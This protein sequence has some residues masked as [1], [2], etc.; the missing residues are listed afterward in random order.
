MLTKRRVL[1]VKQETTPGTAESLSASEG[2]LVVFDPDM[3][4][5]IDMQSRDGAGHLGQRAAVPGA[6]SAQCTFS[7][8]LGGSGSVGAPTPNWASTLL[9]ACGWTDGDADDTYEPESLDPSDGSANT[10]TLTLGLYEDG[11][12]KSMRGCMGT[13]QITGTAG[14]RVMVEFT[15]TGI[16]V[17]DPTDV[18]LIEPSYDTVTPLRFADCDLQV[19]AKHL[20]LAELTVDAG[21]DVQLREDAE[22]VSGYAY[23]YIAGRAPSV[24]VNPEAVLVATEDRFGDWLDREEVALALAIPD[25]SADGNRV[26]I[27]A[28][29]LQYMNVQAADRNGLVVDDLTFQC[30]ASG[31]QGDD[32]LTL[33]FS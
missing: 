12:F 26:D 28:P 18:S 17:D 31:D 9:P 24:T 1:A 33:T 29:K 30:N 19:N 14:Q 25:V 22:D 6:Y 7:V 27:D 5:N 11:R 8:E 13:F 10:K 15:F 3:Q 21:N 2:N 16:W 4:A 32:E 23:A 20:R